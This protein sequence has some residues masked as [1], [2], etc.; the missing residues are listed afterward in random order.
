MKD[1]MIICNP[2]SGGGRTGRSW[3]EIASQVRSAGVDFDDA[4][5][6][7]PGE[8]TEL[9]GA[10]AAEGRRL[11]VVAGGDGTVN[12]VANGLLRAAEQ[13]AVAPRLGVLPT[14]TGGDFRRSFGIPDD[15]AAAARVLREGRTRRID[16]G[17]IACVD[18]EGRDQLMHF[19]NIASA[20]I[21]AEVMRRVRHG[22]RVINGEVTIQLA[23]LTVLLRWRNRRIRALIDEERLEVVAQQ[24]VV[25]NC[26]YYGGGMRVAPRAVPDDGLLDVLVV[27]DVNLLDNARGMP[28]L[29]SGTHLDE[30][31]PKLTYR[32]A[33]RVELE[34]A[35][36]VRVEVDGEL[37]GGLPATF[38]VVPGALELVV[39]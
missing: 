20:G 6:T 26:Q 11:V 2:A 4:L 8:A 12:E 10:A 1:V 23:S 31:N 32:R 7:C 17:R 29:R 22:P 39:P 28:K 13:G 37:P 36:L 30:E 33:R 27:G 14:G 38:E 3:H 5:T 25:A 15:L 9:A 35:E 19:V 24:V 21:G 16:A 34:S 18:G